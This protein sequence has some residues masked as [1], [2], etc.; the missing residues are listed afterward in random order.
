MT[1]GLTVLAE[2]GWREYAICCE[3]ETHIPHISTLAAL[4]GTGFAV[5]A[6]MGCLGGWVLDWGRPMIP[7]AV[8][9]TVWVWLRP[10]TMSQVGLLTRDGRLG[11]VAVVQI[12]SE[13]AGFAAGLGSLLLGY[14]VLSLAIGKVALQVVET[15]GTLALTRSFAVVR[16]N[17]QIYRTI[18]RFSRAILSARVLQFLQG[19]YSTMAVGAAYNLTNVG[20][21]RA[22]VRIVGAAQ[23]TVREPARH[24]GW[25][26][27][28]AAQVQDAASDASGTLSARAA[29][30]YCEV[31]FALAGPLFITLG[32]MSQQVTA[33]LLGAKW[34]P[35]AP[36]ITILAIAAC[37]RLLGTVVEP[38]FAL[39]LRTDLVQR[40]TFMVTGS[41]MILLTLALPFGLIALAWSDVI[42]GLIS[43]PLAMVLLRREGGIAIASFVRTLTPSLAGWAACLLA[44]WLFTVSVNGSKLSL[45]IHLALAASA[46]TLCHL[47]VMFA[48]KRWLM[49]APALGEEQFV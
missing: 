6:M 9:L 27:M 15:G 1:V 33:L 41:N 35:S 40:F 26:T 44:V 12:A 38:L 4:T 28:R 43:I 49:R 34:Q 14:G 22:A 29:L 18:I 3:D 39:K 19:N 8:L 17:W 45:V 46:A 21:Y 13:V 11:A 7:T 32:V 30:R 2:A 42:G 10:L 23:E 24:L 31:L 47:T 48:V 25:S 16:P 36:L 37:T 5:I 20:L